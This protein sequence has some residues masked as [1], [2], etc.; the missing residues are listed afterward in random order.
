MQVGLEDSALESLETRRR[1]ILAS[2]LRSQLR[3]FQFPTFFY[4]FDFPAQSY[5]ISLRYVRELAPFLHPL[6][7]SAEQRRTPHT[8]VSLGREMFSSL[9]LCF[10]TPVS[11]KIDANIS[12]TLN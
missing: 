8:S 10:D 2:S 3:N 5:I 6:T 12:S 4:P 1:S 7:S 11:V 9:S